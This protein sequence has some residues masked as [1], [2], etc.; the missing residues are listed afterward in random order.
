MAN[1][2]LALVFAGIYK[3]MRPDTTDKEAYRA[4]RMKVFEMMREL[5]RTGLLSNQG[6]FLNAAG[7]SEAWDKGQVYFRATDSSPVV[8]GGL[9]T[10][11]E[12]EGGLFQA[13]MP[14][15]LNVHDAV[16]STEAF[17]WYWVRMVAR[18]YGITLE[19]SRHVGH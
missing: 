8:P 9:F 5:S 19:E 18:N 14:Y 16:V 10:V 2:N 11:I 13:A 1:D 12:Q 4:W 17:A 6:A 7:M 15:P 3:A